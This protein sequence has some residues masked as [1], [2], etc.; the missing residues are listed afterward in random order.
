MGSNGTTQVETSPN[1]AATRK[2]RATPWV[3]G[4]ATQALK[5][6]NSMT[7]AVW[8][9]PLQGSESAGGSHSQGVALGF[10][11]AALSGLQGDALSRVRRDLS[12][13]ENR[14][15]VLLISVPSVTS[16]SIVFFASG[17]RLGRV[18]RGRKGE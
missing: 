2:P 13:Y 8:V 5:G 12:S 18:I 11:I 3:G 1:G 6:R 16:C 17:R 10:R 7:G 14:G 15:I 4:T 9:S